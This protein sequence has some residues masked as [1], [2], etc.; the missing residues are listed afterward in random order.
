M[1]SYLCGNASDIFDISQVEYEG[2]LEV[3][4]FRRPRW[5]RPQPT[6]NGFPVGSRRRRRN[7]RLGKQG[8]SAQVVRRIQQVPRVI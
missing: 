2:L 1:N 3:W 7:I 4:V 8:V 6:V 5:S